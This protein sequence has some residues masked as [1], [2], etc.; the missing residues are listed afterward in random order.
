MKHGLGQLTLH[1]DC[2]HPCIKHT[3]RSDSRDSIAQC[4]LFP[5]WLP[6]STVL[7]LGCATSYEPQGP[8][9]PPGMAHACQCLLLWIL[10]RQEYCLPTCLETFRQRAG[11]EPEVV[12]FLSVFRYSHVDKCWFVTISKKHTCC[13]GAGSGW[14]PQEFFHF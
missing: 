5:S 14:D 4:G 3:E 13:K 10:R 8:A 6:L 9:I 1:W 12:F 2:Q 7:N 11:Q